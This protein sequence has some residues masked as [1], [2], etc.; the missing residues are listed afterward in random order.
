[1]RAILVL[2]IVA[3]LAATVA[4]A[5]DY[6]FNMKFPLGCAPTVPIFNFKFDKCEVV[7]TATILAGC[8][9]GTCNESGENEGKCTCTCTSDPNSVPLIDIP[10]NIINMIGGK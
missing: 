6:V 9:T 4:N 8:T 2:S 1:M 7:C 5:D 3:V 10:Q